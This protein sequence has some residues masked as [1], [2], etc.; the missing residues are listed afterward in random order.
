MWRHLTNDRTTESPIKYYL[1]I[2]CALALLFYTRLG[3]G[4]A[5]K[6]DAE[7]EIF[8]KNIYLF[9]LF[10]QTTINSGLILLKNILTKYTL[11]I[12]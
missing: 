7:L 11:Y 1:A 8:L 3:T 10:F 2:I 9:Q 4:T 12:N 6:A 5:N